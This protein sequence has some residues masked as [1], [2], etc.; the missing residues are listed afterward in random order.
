MRG[1]ILPEV[2]EPLNERRSLKAVGS[3][4]FRIHR[5]QIPNKLW[6]TRLRGCEDGL[7]VLTS[8]L[9]SWVCCGNT[10]EPLRMTEESREHARRLFT[11]TEGGPLDPPIRKIVRER[12]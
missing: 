5:L 3:N 10:L 7:S 6:T 8:F 2:K 11:S 1:E 4:L 9:G 12:Q